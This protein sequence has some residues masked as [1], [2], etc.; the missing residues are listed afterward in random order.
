MQEE[1]DV[2]PAVTTQDG[3]IQKVTK[4]QEEFFQEMVET[5][6]RTRNITVIETKEEEEEEKEKEDAETEEENVKKEQAKKTEGE[7][8]EEEE[9][10]GSKE[11]TLL[12]PW[13]SEVCQIMFTALSA[14][15]CC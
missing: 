12:G 6:V 13:E 11:K 10:E 4:K 1:E 7:E 5:T 15:S 3:E 14:S 8:Q 2:P 9:V